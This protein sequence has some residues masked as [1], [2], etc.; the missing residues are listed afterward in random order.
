M[1]AAYSAIVYG[2]FIA[3]FTQIKVF[4]WPIR[5]IRQL[6]SNRQ[7]ERKRS[8]FIQLQDINTAGDR[9]TV[10]E[11]YGSGPGKNSAAVST[12]FFTAAYSAIV[13]IPFVALFT[14]IKV[15]TWP[16]YQF[17]TSYLNFSRAINILNL[18][19][20]PSICLI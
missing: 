14:Q 12:A 1:I 11:Y 7:R 6:Y 4:T 15:F 13:Y 20:R 18:D 9:T 17:L 5:Q 2:Y 19:Q 10:Y 8:N 16:I 3:L